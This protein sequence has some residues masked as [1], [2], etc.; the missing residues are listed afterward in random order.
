MWIILLFWALLWIP[1]ALLVRR[2]QPEL[3]EGGWIVTLPLGYLGTFTLVTPVAWLG[4][5][6]GWPLWVLTAAI[7]LLIVAALA[8]VAGGRVP[9]PAIPSLSPVAIAATVVILAELVASAQQGSHFG[10][11]AGFHVA[12]IRSLLDDGFNNVSPLISGRLERVYFGNLYHAVAAC[13]A[14]VAGLAPADAW[15]HLL[16]FAKLFIAGGS[17]VLAYALLRERWAAWLA[18]AMSAVW[19]GPLTILS[20]PNKFSPLGL[21]P[22]GIALWVTAV[23]APGRVAGPLSLAAAAMVIAEVHALYS[24]LLVLS[25]APATLAIGLWRMRRDRARGMW[26]LVLLVAM[27]AGGP[28]LLASRLAPESGTSMQVRGSYP[29]ALA[30][31]AL[32][33][34]DKP[35]KKV[36]SSGLKQVGDGLYMA[37]PARWFGPR[38]PYLYLLLLPALLAIRRRDTDPL[39]LLAPLMSL[40]FFLYNPWLCGALVRAAGAPWVV[41]RFSIAYSVVLQAAMPGLVAATLLLLPLRQWARHLLLLSVLVAAVG[42]ANAN[43]TNKS[44]W[45]RGPI[46]ERLSGDGTLAPR[47]EKLREYRALLRAHAVPGSLV[48]T[49]PKK[50]Y[51]L[52]MLHSVYPLAIHP[53][54][55]T[56][57]VADMRRRQR[58]APF[59]IGNRGSG[60]LK[61]ALAQH[62]GVRYLW[63]SRK[64]ERKV[65]RAYGR[66]VA[67]VWRVH[68]R[69]L[70]ELKP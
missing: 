39:L 46:A 2:F 37:S 57:G 47:L 12:R 20:Y 8:L 43:G 19:W 5:I 23:R 27:G 29:D 18:A 61:V 41:G 10:G 45:K 35:V 55:G 58:D 65:R 70:V 7:C 49:K 4:F 17:A 31:V 3:A 52:L 38:S 66:H 24:V 33:A 30:S 59:L 42:Y 21:L 51:Q 16:S 28:Q 50:D 44:V 62:Y 40:S 11:D 34:V 14:Q 67:G 64:F 68:G 25:L 1:G 22:I 26:T 60:P 48:C 15:A 53:V 56:A 6:F 13:S 63:L 69:L 54:R 36:K 9:R 32:P